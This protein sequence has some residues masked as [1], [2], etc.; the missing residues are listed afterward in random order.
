M[1]RR[2]S[3]PNLATKWRAD[4]RATAVGRRQ[5]GGA[6]RTTARGCGRDRKVA[7]LI[8]ND[9]LTVAIGMQMASSTAHREPD[10]VRCN[11]IGQFKIDS[12][13]THVS[14]QLANIIRS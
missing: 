12:G 13:S 11:S 9:L 4:A 1:V 14:H 6:G 10:D 7:R 8:G 2:K 5:A 3:D